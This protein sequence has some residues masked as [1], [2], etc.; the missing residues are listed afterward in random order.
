MSKTEKKYNYISIRL[1][2]YVMSSMNVEN[3]KTYT[4]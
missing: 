3:W 1:L 2:K 4:Q